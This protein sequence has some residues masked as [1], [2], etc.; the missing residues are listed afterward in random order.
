[1]AVSAGSWQSFDLL[2]RRREELGL[3]TVK[4][5]SSREL[6]LRGGLI[7]ASL[8]GLAGVI[9]AGCF[10]YGGWLQGREDSRK[11]VGDGELL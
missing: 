9:L 8:V 11:P 3:E 1:M 2:R 6:L 7:A 5:A 4:P 10:V